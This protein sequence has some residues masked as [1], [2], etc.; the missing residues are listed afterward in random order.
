MHFH[1]TKLEIAWNEF[2][3]IMKSFPTYSIYLFFPFG[4]GNIGN[5]IPAICYRKYH[6]FLIIIW[7]QLLFTSFN[8]TEG[9]LF[10]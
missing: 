2:R 7:Q 6:V 8:I 4:L 9:M 3:C 10:A 1:V 5:F